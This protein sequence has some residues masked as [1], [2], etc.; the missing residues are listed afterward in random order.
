VA[1]AVLAV[2]LEEVFGGPGDE[3][4]NAV[5]LSLLATPVGFAALTFILVALLPTT[6]S[7][8]ALVAFLYYLY[9]FIIAS[10]VVCTIWG[11]FALAD[12]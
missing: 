3:V 1:G 8:A 11:C 2:I 4:A 6:P 10:A 5:V 12:R 9:A 7:R